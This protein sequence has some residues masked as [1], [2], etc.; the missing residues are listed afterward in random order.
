VTP[1]RV[2][3]LV[4]ADTTRAVEVA[5][6]KSRL[7]I[8]VST[9]DAV[10]GS[11]ADDLTSQIVEYMKGRPLAL[12]RY[13][14]TII[15]DGETRLLLSRMPV[16]AGSVAVTI[17]ATADTDWSLE[18]GGI[19]Y[20]ED[21]WDE[22]TEPNVVVTYYAGWLMPG[23]VSAWSAAQSVAAGG[24]IEPS[25]PSLSPMLFQATAAGTTHATTEPTWPTVA[26]ETVTDNGITWTARA[27]EELPLLVRGCA[28]LAV[29]DAFLARKDRSDL[30]AQSAGI[31]S[32]Q[33]APPGVATARFPGV[34][35]EQVK[36]VLDGLRIAA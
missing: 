13:R 9:H 25:A 28:Y 3:T 24:W 27:V 32:E 20:R 30:A 11:I 14:E 8:T 7:G 6:V 2:E 19:L 16:E 26:A 18:D 12:Q 17:D 31:F 23:V 34:L 21:G 1:R 33:Y 4:R 29:R 36:D 35:S 10:I 22:D 5:E 15:G